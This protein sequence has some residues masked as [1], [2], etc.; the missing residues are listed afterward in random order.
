[1]LPRALF[2]AL[3]GRRL[4]RFVEQILQRRFVENGTTELRPSFGRDNRPQQV[5]GGF[6]AHPLE[7]KELRA[8]ERKDISRIPHESRVDELRDPQNYGSRA[9]RGR[10][11]AEA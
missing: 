9:N 10:P 7:A 1:M 3:L 2:A 4:T 5:I 11:P 8:G 6:F